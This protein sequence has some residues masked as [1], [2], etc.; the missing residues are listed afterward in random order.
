MCFREAISTKINSNSTPTVGRD[1]SMVDHNVWPEITA[2]VQP[3]CSSLIFFTL[4]KSKRNEVFCLIDGMALNVNLRENLSCLVN[5]PQ[6][7]Q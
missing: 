7:Q 1:V 2:G 5:K 4:A 6:I 3:Q